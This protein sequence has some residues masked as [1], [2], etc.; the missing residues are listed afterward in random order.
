MMASALTKANVIDVLD[1]ATI[2]ENIVCSTHSQGCT[3]MYG[4]CKKCKVSFVLTTR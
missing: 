3:C 4:L 2:V 1:M